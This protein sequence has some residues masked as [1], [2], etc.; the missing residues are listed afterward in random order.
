MWPSKWRVFF[1]IVCP[2][3]WATFQVSIANLACVSNFVHIF[4][5][6]LQNWKVSKSMGAVEF[7]PISDVKLRLIRT[8][9]RRM[10][11]RSKFPFIFRNEKEM[12]VSLQCHS[13]AIYSGSLLPAVFLSLVKDRYPEHFIRSIEVVGSRMWNSRLPISKGS[14]LFT[15]ARES[16]LS[17]KDSDQIISTLSHVDSR[18]ILH[19]NS[20]EALLLGV[21]KV[22]H[23]MLVLFTIF[24]YSI[25]L[26]C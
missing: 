26:S 4:F 15:C 14:H 23:H 11:R 24:M 25:V 8:Y 2:N 12:H 18:Q 3:S 16:G 17:F 9:E 1:D 22:C 19:K 6:I 10:C 7:I 21:R 13:S 5:Q 20:E